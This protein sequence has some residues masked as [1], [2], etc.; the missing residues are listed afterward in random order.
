MSELTFETFPKICRL[1]RECTITEKIDGTN[2]QLV[3]SEDGDLLV[4]SRNREIFPKGTPGQDKDCDNFGLARWAYEHKDKLFAYLGPGR[5]YGEWA[6]KGIQ[7]GYGLDFKKFFLFNTARW[8]DGATEVPPH[9]SSIGL[10]V[11]PHLFTGTFSTC[12]VDRMMDELELWGSRVNDFDKPE[13]IIVYHHALRQSF[14]LTYEY[15]RTGKG[16]NR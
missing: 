12:I 8:G 6:G 5:H 16:D 10:D 15:D 7:R 3:F 13:G 4:G 1:K 11:V 9:L 2:G 14:K